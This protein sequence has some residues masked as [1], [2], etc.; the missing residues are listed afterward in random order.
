MRAC[1]RK[2]LGETLSLP[3]MED[4]FNS[5]QSQRSSLSFS[6]V[7]SGALLRMRT[8]TRQA[9]IEKALPLVRFAKIE[10]GRDG[11][12]APVHLGPVLIQVRR[13]R[14]LQAPFPS[15]SYSPRPAPG[16]A[17]SGYSSVSGP[18]PVQVRRVYGFSSFRLG[19]IVTARRLRSTWVRLRSRSAAYGACK[20]PSRPTRTRHGRLRGRPG[21]A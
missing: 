18:A 3:K 15:D 20:L 21:L 11:P 12:S 9:D 8:S 1:A 2:T 14:G 10:L 16:Q 6:S 17:R 13:V 5:M 7:H 4:R 19:H